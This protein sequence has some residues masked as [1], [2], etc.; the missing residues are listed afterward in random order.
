MLPLHSQ[1]GVQIRRLAD[2]FY[3]KHRRFGWSRLKDEHNVWARS[4]GKPEA[5]AAIRAALTE[6]LDRTRDAPFD[7]NPVNSLSALF[8]HMAVDLA[9]TEVGGGLPVTAAA[10]CVPA[11]LLPTYFCSALATII[12]QTAG[13]IPHAVEA[14]KV[15]PIE[16]VGLER[17]AKG[18]YFE[19]PVLVRHELALGT[20]A[21]AAGAAPRLSL[22]QPASISSPKAVTAASAPEAK[23]ASV[24][25]VQPVLAADDKPAAPSGCCVAF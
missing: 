16:L 18:S 19:P 13:V 20:V 14:G 22:S 24:D 9:G 1:Q 23:G 4:A 8:S 17:G 11:A 12:Y 5:R 10:P 6:L 15:A 2:T 21:P 3:E 7:F 25:Q